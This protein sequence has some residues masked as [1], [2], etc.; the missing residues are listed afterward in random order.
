[1][2]HRQL[3]ACAAISLAMAVF[4]AAAEDL[5]I[6]LASEPTAVDPHYHDVSPNNALAMHIFSALGE[7]D[8]DQN[9][10]PSL[11]LSWDTEDD[12]TWV[13]K[14]RD[15]VTFS[16]GSKFDADD[17]IFTFCRVMNNEG[18]VAATASSE[19]TNFASVEAP[20]PYT[21]RIKTKNV[22]PLLPEL[23]SQILVLSDGIVEHGD[24]SFDLENDCGVTGAWPTVD[25]FNNGDAAIGTGPFVLEKF[26]KGAGI[27]ISRNEN[28]WGKAPEWDK[29]SFVPVP[30]AGPRLAGLLSGDYDLIENPAARDIGQIEKRDDLEYTAAA[31][32][33]VIFLQMD[34]GREDS[35]FVEADDGSNPFQDERVRRAVSL[36]IDRQAIVDRIMD[37]FA[38]PA[39]QFVPDGMFGGIENPE[40]LNYD[41]ERAKELLVEAGYPDGFK[42]TFHATNDR[43]INDSQVAQAIAQF[44]TRVGIQT[45]LDAMTRSIFFTRRSNKEF[46]FSMGGWGSSEGGAASFLRQ[47]VTTENDDLGVGASNYGAWS[48]PE[49][50]EV[51]LKAI[52]TIDENERKALLQKAEQMA[53]DKLGFIPIHF[54]SSI[55]AHRKGLNYEGRK[56]QYTLAYKITSDA[57]E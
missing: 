57:G 54:E 48:D 3:S 19:V 11:A 55:W 40:P 51:L 23:L 10:H 45:E 4:P 36:A 18:S 37:G 27:T 28:Y 30:S 22:E 29:V 25:D 15:D 13:F 49:F 39:Y 46:S 7:L 41:P 42:I 17:V 16:D 44:L 12:N 33:R 8:A 53:V 47:Y 6:G 50:D 21:I 38:Q 9:V 1:M 2:I 20:D 43:Y 26:S 34:I 5:T 35:P 52:T 56:D 32:N 31:S 24:L 14:L